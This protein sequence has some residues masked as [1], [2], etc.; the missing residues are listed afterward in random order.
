VPTKGQIHAIIT[1]AGKFGLWAVLAAFLVWKLQT[2]YDTEL[3]A[4][5]VAINTLSA[6]IDAHQAA[7]DRE[8]A[9]RRSEERITRTL[10][11][12]ICLG[13]SGDLPQAR[14]LCDIQQEP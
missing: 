3:K 7:M 10:L 12:G 8:L 6:K 9:D 5:T 13:T 1:L 14:V 2:S 11:R 4:Q